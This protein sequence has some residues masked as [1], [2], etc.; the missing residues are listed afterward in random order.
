MELVL[1]IEEL[2]S[3][4]EPRVSEKQARPSGILN[5][6]YQKV[7]AQN[8]NNSSSQSIFGIKQYIR[9]RQYQSNLSIGAVLKVSLFAIIFLIIF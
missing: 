8:L 4:P 3:L 1:P 7:V 6:N 5:S 2:E 9:S